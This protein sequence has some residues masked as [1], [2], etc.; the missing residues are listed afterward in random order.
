MIIGIYNRQNDLKIDKRAARTLVLATLSYLKASFKEVTI[1][2]V[3]EKRIAKIHD[4]FFQDPTST[5]CISF[6]ID[7]EH[8]GEIFV[9][10]AVALQ[11]AKK[12]GLDPYNETALYIIH[13]LLHLLGFD[14]LGQEERRTMR[15]KEKSCM[16][17]L[18]RLKIA[19]Q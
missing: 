9:C 3:T 12:K 17:H 14:D 11:Y 10:P 5:D 7:Q 18:D 16:R 1:Y 15:K 19:L 2:F 13:G 8:L 4:Q 6:P